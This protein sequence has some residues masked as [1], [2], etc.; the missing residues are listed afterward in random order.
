ME[1]KE[2][3]KYQLYLNDLNEYLAITQ[4]IEQKLKNTFYSYIEN[5]IQGKVDKT[6]TDKVA[7]KYYDE[8]SKFLGKKV[9]F[10][11][12]IDSDYR[13]ERIDLIN[14]QLITEDHKKIK[15][16]DLGTGQSQSAYLIGLLN[17]SDERKMIVLFDE[18]A[19]MDTKSL[20]PVYARL[21]EL[22]KDGKLLCGI[23]VQKADEAKTRNIL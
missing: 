13:V 3:H 7:L 5:L 20:E 9:G 21:K 4:K 23:I 17:I 6:G 14:N 19:M 22:Y 11:R 12:H 2:E 15:L 18:V 1:K 8:V 10:I 16:A